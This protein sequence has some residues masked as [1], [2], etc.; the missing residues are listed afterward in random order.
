MRLRRDEHQEN[1]NRLA[2]VQAY[3]TAKAEESI[4][5]KEERFELRK[6]AAA[7][8]AAVRRAEE[9]ATLR[10]QAELKHQLDDDLRRIREGDRL[11]LLHAAS[12]AHSIPGLSAISP[13]SGADAD[14]AGADPTHADPGGIAAGADPAGA[15]DAMAGAERR[16]APGSSRLGRTSRRLGSAR[17]ARQG[18]ERDPKPSVE[19]GSASRSTLAGSRPSRAFSVG[20]TAGSMAGSMGGPVDAAGLEALERIRRRQNERL[21]R[22]LEAEQEREMTRNDLLLSPVS[23][24]DQKRLTK[25]IQLERGMAAREIRNL[26]EE[27]EL[28]LADKMVE[29]KITR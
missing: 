3:I 29:L 6:A 4:H 13:P 27:H 5:Q 22:A 2:R 25:L 15:E 14:T 7:R 1:Q 8:S 16:V 12:A 11:S 23:A 9:A 19:V 28:E 17:P 21:L 20:S 26:T 24:A 18:S 10:A